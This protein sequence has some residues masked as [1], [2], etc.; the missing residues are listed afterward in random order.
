[1]RC[2]ARQRGELYVVTGPA[3]VGD[4]IYRIGD[5]RVLVPSATWNGGVD[6]DLV[7]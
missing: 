7:D 5:N 4:Q 1:V 2:L 6:G 3:F